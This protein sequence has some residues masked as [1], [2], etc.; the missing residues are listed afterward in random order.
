MK[1]KHLKRGFARA[2]SKGCARLF[3][4]CCH[5]NGPGTCMI[6]VSPVLVAPYPVPFWTYVFRITSRLFSRTDF[7]PSKIPVALRQHGP[8]QVAADG[9]SVDIDVSLI[10]CNRITLLTIS[11][12]SLLGSL[13]SL[14]I[15]SRSCILF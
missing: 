14:L 4:H 15:W 10:W 5:G 6:S 1:F 3:T 2:R 9:F 11:L 12:R 8:W 13:S 7:R